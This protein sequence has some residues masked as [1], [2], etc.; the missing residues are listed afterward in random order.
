MMAFLKIM[1]LYVI[2]NNNGKYQPFE[3]YPQP[4]NKLSKLTFAVSQPQRWISSFSA[5]P[6][7]QRP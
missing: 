3:Y 5:L 4:L 1:T 7:Q 2:G 6:N